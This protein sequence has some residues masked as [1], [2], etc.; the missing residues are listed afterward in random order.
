MRDERNHITFL[1]SCALSTPSMFSS[2]GIRTYGGKPRFAAD[3]HY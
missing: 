1:L 2:L 3:K